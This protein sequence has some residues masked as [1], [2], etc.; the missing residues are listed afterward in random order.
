[1]DSGLKLLASLKDKEAVNPR[2][3]SATTMADCGD[4]QALK[5]KVEE[6]GNKVRSLKSAK[7]DKVSP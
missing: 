1:L 4:A 3:K 2:S 6:Q 7:A 5:A